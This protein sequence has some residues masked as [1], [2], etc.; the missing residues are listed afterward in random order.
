MTM[1]REIVFLLARDK[2]LEQTLGL[3][4][5]VREA[6]EKRGLKLTACPD[7]DRDGRPGPGPGP[8]RPGRALHLR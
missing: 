5:A 8:R 7:R 3:M 4:P 1:M 6:L 2:R